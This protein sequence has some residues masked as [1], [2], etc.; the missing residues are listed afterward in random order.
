ME[1]PVSA[2]SLSGD[3]AETGE[4]LMSFRICEG[5]GAKGQM[6]NLIQLAKR[7]MQVV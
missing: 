7:T 1:E 5:G 6:R 4:K 2:G 3:P